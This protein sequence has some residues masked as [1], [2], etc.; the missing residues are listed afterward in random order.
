VNDRVNQDVDFVE[1]DGPDG[2]DEELP[3]HRPGSRI[4]AWRP[5]VEEFLRGRYGLP[6]VVVL[7]VLALLVGR[8]LLHEK[9]AG[10]PS[11]TPSSGSSTTVDS[12]GRAV[13]LPARTGAD[14]TRCPGLQCYTTSSVPAGVRAAIRAR[15]PTAAV[16][17]GETVRLVDRAQADPLWYRQVDAR[18]GTGTLTVRVQAHASGD[19][20]GGG[21]KDD[22]HQ[23]VTYVDSSS[24]Q[25]Y[26]RLQMTDRSG[27]LEPFDQLSS[28]VDDTRLLQV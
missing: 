14:P 10:A 6:A 2:G 1:D 19:T 24:G 3:Q 4:Q 25:W 23:A 15:F 5:R 12:T 22:G 17:V 8:A 26:V 28:L 27:T 18:V 16:T 11:P 9:P 7:A 13:V 21:A 20:P